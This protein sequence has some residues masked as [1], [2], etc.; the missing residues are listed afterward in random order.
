MQYILVAA[1]KGYARKGTPEL[2]AILSSLVAN[3][4]AC[5]ENSYLEIV[6]DKA[7]ELVPSL[8]PAHLDYLTLIFIYIYAF[9]FTIYL[10]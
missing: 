6:L 5:V 8:L 9:I 7:I 4:S 10:H 1:E 2:C 3:R